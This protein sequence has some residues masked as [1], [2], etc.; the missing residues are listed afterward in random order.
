MVL[1]Q[2]IIL[3]VLIILSAFFSGIET[4]LVSLNMIKVRALVKQKKRGSKALFRLK[5]D[6]HKMI[7][8]ILIGNNLVNIGAAS[9]ATVVFTQIFGSSG[10]GIATGVMTFLILVFGEITPKTL[11]SQNAEKVSLMVAK[12]VEVLSYVLSPLVYIFGA[13]SKLITNLF[14]GDKEKLSEEELRTIVTMG[15]REGILSRESADMMHNVLKFEGTKATQIMTPKLEIEMLNAEDTLGKV[16]DFVAKSPYSRF[17]VY[18]KNKDNVIGIVDVDDVLT[19]VKD[20]KMNAKVRKLKKPVHLVPESEE[21]DDLL[22]HF[23]GRHVPMAIVQDKAKKVAGLV[24]VE[25][26]LEEIVGDIF[27]KSERKKARVKKINKKLI[28]ADA[29]ASVE[30][31]NNLLHLGVRVRHFDTL[32]GYLERK[33]GR[34]PRKGEKIKLK[35]VIITVHKIRDNRIESFNIRKL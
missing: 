27:D 31:I 13:I 23:E 7:I 24:T 20:N 5:Q 26:I 30:E 8:T 9:F 25:D 17:P 33:L 21:I 16:I 35:K 19:Y 3:I 6:S 32:A 11:A 14:G 10:V 1:T 15:R 34:V 22:E 28:R 12:P 4:A 29:K 18:H 2:I